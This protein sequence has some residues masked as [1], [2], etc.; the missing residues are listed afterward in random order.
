MPEIIEIYL[1]IAYKGLTSNIVSVNIPLYLEITGDIYMSDENEEMDI[2]ESITSEIDGKRKAPK[3]AWQKG[4][5]GNLAGRPKKGQEKVNAKP[6]S[7]MRNTLGKLYEL[8][9]LAC[10]VIKEHLER[11]DARK[12]DQEKSRL[13]VAKF[14]IKSIESLNNTCLREELAVLGIREK[15]QENADALEENNSVEDVAPSKFSMELAETTLKH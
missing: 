7:K 12:T 13:E 10:E 1:Y 14:V 3:T 8:E 5:S 2:T 4:Q 11:K 9:G 15:N 6:R